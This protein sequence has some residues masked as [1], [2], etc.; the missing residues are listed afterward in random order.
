MGALQLGVV[1][2]VCSFLHMRTCT[3]CMFSWPCSKA[4]SFLTVHKFHCNVV[5]GSLA[6]TGLWMV[7]AGV[8]Q[9][10]S[11]FLNDCFYGRRRS[12]VKSTTARRPPPAAEASHPLRSQVCR[13]NSMTTR[14]TSLTWS[15]SPTQAEPSR[16]AVA[17]QG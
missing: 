16:G 3:L 6:A 7:T 9:R 4:T 14:A 13:Q 11:L 15:C 2:A 17:P 5:H 12:Q 10:L 1:G 8:L